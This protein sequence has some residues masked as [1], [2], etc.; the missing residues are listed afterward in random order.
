M[1]TSLADPAQRRDPH[2]SDPE[3]RPRRASAA[4]PLTRLLLRMHFFAGILVGPFLLIAALSGAAYAIAPTAEQLV[5]RDMLSASS[6]AQ[7]VP[8]ADQVDTARDV[9][10]DLQ[11]SGV[12]PGTGGDTTRVLFAD[13][14]LPSSS[15]SRVVFT[16]PASGEVRGDSVQYGSG[17]ALPLRTW[18]S[19]LHRSL[20]LGD[21]G[22]VYSELAASWLAPIALGGLVMWWMRRRRARAPML[23]AGARLEGRPK[24]RSKHAVAGTWIVVGLFFFSATGLTWSQFAGGNIGELRTALGWTTPALD[25]GAP[26]AEQA[27]GHEAH[28]GHEGHEGHGQQGPAHEGHGPA[29]SPADT[30]TDTDT[31]A[32]IDIGTA[33][34]SARDA[35]LQDPMELT[36]PAG[37][38]APWLVSETRRSW[39]PGPDSVSI[40]AAS[41][42]P[43]EQ[44]RFA[45]YP[46]AAKLTDWGI[47]AHMGFLFGAANQLLLA[48]VALT[49]VGVIVRGYALWW[50]R[51]PGPGRPPTRGALLELVRRRPVL[52]IGGL[53]VV[54]V[55]GWAVPLLGASLVAFLVIDA[56]LGRWGQ[57]PSTA[58]AMKK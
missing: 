8:L 23:R 13:P 38:G 30:D 55:I 1:S 5:Y 17:Q 27:P 46:L 24:A 53:L 15:Y 56:V 6:P 16:D 31:A 2:P 19:E 22:R 47:R 42:E 41:G 54:A 49:L 48:A 21:P 45:D 20:H 4:G 28:E 12:V 29:P 3:H 34:A 33:A 26:A 10:P 40:D 44:I 43:V 9:H 51:R 32:A 25:A 35:G 39:T 52:T 58:R 36:P 18:L 57:R 14:A 37:E 11:L 7:L 50:S